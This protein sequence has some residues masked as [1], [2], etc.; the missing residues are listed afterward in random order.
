[1]TVTLPDTHKM[2]DARGKERFNRQRESPK[3]VHHNRFVRGVI[4]LER[5][6]GPG[7][8]TKLDRERLTHW[9]QLERYRGSRNVE[10]TSQYFG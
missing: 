10:R 1:M 5:K 9:K 3:K 8:L 6:S 7:Q 2:Y 4:S